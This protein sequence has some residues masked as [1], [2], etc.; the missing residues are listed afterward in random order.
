MYFYTFIYEHEFR[1]L[2]SLYYLS[3][4]FWRAF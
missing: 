1:E 2:V 3:Y 4:E